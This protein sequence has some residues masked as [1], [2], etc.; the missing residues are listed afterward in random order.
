MASS[1][2]DSITAYGTGD[3]G[4]LTIYLLTMWFLE[5]WSLAF[6]CDYLK[7]DY[8]VDWL[9]YLRFSFCDCIMW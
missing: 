5:M 2:T 4:V 7:C 3:G 1:G 9:F 6:R 8:I